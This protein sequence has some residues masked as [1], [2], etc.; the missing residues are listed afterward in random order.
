MSRAQQEQVHGAM[1]L[2][3]WLALVIFVGL[4]GVCYV[5]LKQKL[6]VDGN[7][8]RDLE[9]AVLELDE[10]ILGVTSDIRRLTGRPSLERRREEG[11]IRMMEVTDG[12]VVRLRPQT[13]A[14]A[15]PPLSPPEE[16]AR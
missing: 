9:R 12:R 14:A 13:E 16:A 10:K 4:L 15:L 5:H 8:C 7:L 11:F 3:R 1:F 6:T 2:A